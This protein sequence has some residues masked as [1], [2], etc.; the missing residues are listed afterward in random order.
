MSDRKKTIPMIPLAIFAGVAFSAL[1]CSG[2]GAALLLPGIQSVREAARRRQA[3]E[4]LQQIEAA[5]KNYHQ[6]DAA[7]ETSDSKNGDGAAAERAVNRPEYVKC[8]AVL[9][10]Y[11]EDYPWFENSTENGRALHADGKSPLASFVISSPAE[12]ADRKVK[13]LFKYSGGTSVTV[14]GV[15]DKGRAFSFEAPEDFLMGR[16]EIIENDVVRNLS[17]CAP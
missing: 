13:V 6:R 17:R 5:L 16:S 9:S 3:M 4:N 12:Y 10:D 8:Q 7:S 2:I 1:M 11:Q 15:A 14:P